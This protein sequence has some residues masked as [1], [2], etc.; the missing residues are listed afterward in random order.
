MAAKTGVSSV[1]QVREQ[2]N[3]AS[4]SG[5]GTGCPPWAGGRSVL[6]GAFGLLRALE[7]AEEAGLSSLASECGLPKTTA[8]RLLEQLVGLGAVERCGGGYRLGPRMFRLG[9]GWQPYPGLRSVAREPVR[10]LVGATGA[11]VGINVLWEGQTLVLNWASGEA[12]E[13]LG[14]LQNGVAWPWFTAAGKILVAAARPALP[15]GPMPGSW[16]RESAEIRER[17]VAY[18][19]EE[20]V[21][22]VCCVAV[23][24]Y[25]TSGAP[26]ASLCVLTDP[27]HNLERLADVA[28]RTGRAISAGLR[29]TARAV[30]EPTV[31][32][33]VL[34]PGAGPAAEHRRG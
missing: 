31:R 29:G 17:G 22:G 15:L 10:R 26:V 16:L 33:G 27:S 18:D 23:P 12:N 1:S 2:E 32:H 13:V 30:I 9:Q 7:R 5:S 8:H 28:Q 25:G 24:L 21:T 14:P 6:E 4:E 20:V 11:T 34:A 3:R 19:R